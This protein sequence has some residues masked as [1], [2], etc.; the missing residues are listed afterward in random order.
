MNIRHALAILLTCAGAAV[1][2]WSQTSNPAPAAAATFA[3]MRDAQAALD[4]LFRAYERGDVGLIQHRLDPSMIGYQRFVDGMRRDT[5]AQR[6]VRIHVFEAQVTAGPDVAMI[7]A[8]WE[9]RFF[10]TGAFAP[11][12]FSGHSTFLMHRGSGGWKLAAVAGDNP[13]SSE[14]GTLAQLSV[15]PA[16]VSLASLGVRVCTPLGAARPLV[17][18]VV[19]PDL[20]GLASV[21]VEVTTSQGDREAIVLPAVAPG[22]FSSNALPVCASARA[23]IPGNGVVEIDAGSAPPATITVRHIDANPGS[24]GPPRALSRSVSVL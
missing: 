13:F 7:Q 1:P 21:T 5:M 3:E 16:V 23:P 17:L 19:D 12:I 15:A 14:A 22:R 18:E 11:G 24:D 4:E 10:S 9:K 20:A 8:S 2:A 6:H